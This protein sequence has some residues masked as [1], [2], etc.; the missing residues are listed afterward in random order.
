MD[1]T[2]VSG[3]GETYMFT[4]DSDNNI[5]AHAAIPG[6]LENLQAFASEKEL[7][8]LSAEWP[9]SSLVEVWNSFAGVAPFT[10]KERGRRDQSART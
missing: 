2:T 10:E 4:I 6:S 7:A 3:Q 5:A 9:G 1:V 8:K